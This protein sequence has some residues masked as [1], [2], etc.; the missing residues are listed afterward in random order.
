MT[1]SRKTIITAAAAIAAL[2]A[3]VAAQAHGG[4]NG[5]GHAQRAPRAPKPVNVIVKGSVVAVNGNVVTVAVMRANHHG[6]AF[7]GQQVQLDVTAARV[8]VK[9]ANADGSRNV[10][11]V[12]A[13]DRVVAQLRVSRGV[14][15]DLTQAFATRRLLDVGPAPAPTPE[16]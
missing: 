6:R 14:T 10:A 16:S 9:D 4:G 13:G 8:S 1:N 3:P 5:H 11:D 2:C 12:A 15:P 7:V